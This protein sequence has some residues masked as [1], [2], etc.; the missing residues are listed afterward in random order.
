MRQ[1]PDTRPMVKSWLTQIVR[2][3]REVAPK[4][5]KAAAFPVGVEVTGNDASRWVVTLDDGKV[6]SRTK[7]DVKLTIFVP[8]PH[9]RALSMHLRYKYWKEAFDAQNLRVHSEDAG[10]LKRLKALASAVEKAEAESATPPTTS[11]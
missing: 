8:Q 6:E 7:E 4:E 1:G 11:P 9:V 2:K 5:T 10:Q 3:I